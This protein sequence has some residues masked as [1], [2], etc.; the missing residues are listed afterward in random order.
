M[1]YVLNSLATLLIVFVSSVGMS[2]SLE[3]YNTPSVRQIIPLSGTWRFKVGDT[4]ASAAQAIDDSSWTDIKVPANWY[5]E[6]YDISG[7]AWYK[8]QFHLSEALKG[9]RISL[10]FG[11]VD[12]TTDIWLNGHYLGSHEGYFQPFSFDVTDAVALG[13]ENTLLV[14]VN[15]PLE[16]VG[17]DWSLHKRLIKGIFAHHDTRPGGAW[18]DRA[19]ERNTGG[20]W[21]DVNLEVHEVAHIEAVQVSPKLYLE[22]NQATA[23]VAFQIAL[24]QNSKL[25]TKVRITLKPENFSAQETTTT[26]I[27]QIL[28]PGK[29]QITVPITV[30]NPHLWWPWDQG[31]PNLYAI[32]IAVLKKNKIIDSQRVIFGFRSVNYDKEKQVWL[33]NGKRLFLRGTNY[34]ATQWLSEMTAAR[35]GYDIGLMK[36]ANVNIVRVHAHITAADFYRQCDEAGLLI[37]QDFPL[38]WGYADDET[39]RNNAVKQAQ[40]MVGLFYN[41][42][43]IIMWSMINEPV[44]D[45]EWMK[46]K[47]HS[48]RKDYNKQL[49]DALYQ[50]IEP[51]DKTRYVH[52]YSSTAEHPWL[53]WYSG[54]WLD[55]NKPTKIAMVAE[56]GA[57][58]LPDL[59]SLR[60]IFNENELWPVTDKQWQKWEYHNFQRKETFENAKVPRGDSIAEF[61]QNTQQYQAKLIKLAAESYRRQRYQPVNSIFQFMFVEDWPSMNWGVVD[62]WRTP[63]PGYYA[64]KQA[65]QPVLPSIAWEKESFNSGEAA[66]FSLWVINDLLK[67]F[68]KA[69]L[70][71]SLRNSQTL[72]ETNTVELDIHP[73]TGKEVKTLEW[74]NLP[75]GH[76]EIVAQIADNR[77]KSLGINTHE[78]EINP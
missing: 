45:A 6:G 64:L 54:S 47:Y 22:K 38:Q 72:L 34:I 24:Q 76:Y 42:P 58:A 71:Y 48:Y 65:Y 52:P 39:F 27:Q 5:L 16:T 49:T 1:K 53:G 59:S 2:H 29:N 4:A 11:G 23:K 78:F 7:I 13:A 51:L 20:I 17:E 73:D 41:H 69:R 15:S 55:Y 9:K 25:A 40:E 74:N 46:Y 61:I 14:K 36:N 18:S 12:Y 44:W 67:S 31:E 62:Y 19:Q 8:K 26:Q 21:A 33:I 50:A 75:S 60:K 57:Q 28:Q 32:D 68:P 66:Q 30:N 35:F 56:Y 3:S 10:N 77:G 43:S 63:K 37:W 70:S